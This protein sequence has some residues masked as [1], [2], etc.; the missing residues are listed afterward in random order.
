M[1]CSSQLQV[2]RTNARFSLRD[3]NEEFQLPPQH[4]AQYSSL[5]LS[6]GVVIEMTLR[7][8]L[9][10]ETP[11]T[12]SICVPNAEICRDTDVPDFC[13]IPHLC[14]SHQRVQAIELF[15][16]LGSESAGGTQLKLSASPHFPHLGG[17]GINGQG[18]L[19]TSLFDLSLLVPMRSFFV[20]YITAI[21]ER[22][23]SW[24][25]H[26]QSLLMP[27]RL[28]PLAKAGLARQPR[29]NSYSGWSGNWPQ[30]PQPAFDPVMVVMI[31]LYVGE[32][33]NGHPG[34]S[35]SDFH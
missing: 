29:P 15:T 12:Q 30:A 8:V 20:E 26:S 7:R 4:P 31:V 13:L 9:G 34:V 24:F 1:H 6:N 18:F 33:C 16:R 25:T 19:S 21:K 10:R 11:D 35:L 28:S 2:E 17:V 22:E 3:S 23:R 27:P 5:A 32:Y 14:T